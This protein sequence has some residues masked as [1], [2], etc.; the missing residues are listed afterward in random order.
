MRAIFCISAVPMPRVV[1]AGVPSRSPLA[2]IA[3]GVLGTYLLIKIVDLVASGAWRDLLAG[4]W[5]SWLYLFELLMAAIIPITL[6]AL[7]R[8]RR[9]PWGLGLSAGLAAAG[10][11]LNRLDVGI[12]GY[13]RDAGVPYFPSAVEWALGLGIIA[14]AGLVFLAIAAN[15]PIFD[16]DWREGWARRKR[17][18]PSFDAFTQVWNTALSNSLHR[19]TL[20]AVIVLKEPL[21]AV[22]IGAAV[23]IV[24]GLVLIRLH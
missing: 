4:S 14:A 7:P 9:S 1:R 8:T 2:T 20:I 22:R 17:F 6:V 18:R 23:L 21:R 11:A 12:F 3:A 5:E 24:Y 13:W 19:V 15:F 10:L 16:E